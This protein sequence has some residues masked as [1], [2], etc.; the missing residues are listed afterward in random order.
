MAVM[1]RSAA[2]VGAIRLARSV[3]GT[4]PGCHDNRHAWAM[5]GLAIQV[6]YLNVGGYAGITHRC[7]GPLRARG[8]GR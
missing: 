8:Y 7:A 2:A 6:G 4:L 1:M 3:T 5:P